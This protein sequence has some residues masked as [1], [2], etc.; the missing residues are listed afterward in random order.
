MIETF[1]NNPQ[2]RRSFLR[3]TSTATLSAGAILLLAGSTATAASSSADQESDAKILN[4]ALGLEHQ[5]IAAYGLGAPLLSKP[6]LAIALKF[7]K[8]HEGHRDALAKAIGSI[9][10][11]PVAALSTDAYAKAI[12]AASLKNEGDV[13]KAAAGLELGAAN[14]YI[15]V[16]AGFKNT[17]YA[18]VAARLAADEVSHWTILNNALGNQPLGTLGFGA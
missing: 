5:A 3:G 1:S 6:V 4:I 7:L 12:N 2:S 11:K 9:G 13:L 16:I 15:S 8:D 17:A 18:T 14:A 10:G